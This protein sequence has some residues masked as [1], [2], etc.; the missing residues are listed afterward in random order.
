MSFLF[1]TK[2]S[3]V[4]TSEQIKKEHVLKS[5]EVYQKGIANVLDVIA[6]S[7]INITPNYIQL[8]G[9]Y[10]RTLFVHTYSK[11]LQTNWLSPVIN[12]DLT[13][14]IGMFIYPV[15]SR[16]ILK[17]LRKK[18]AQIQSSIIM[19]QEKGEVRDPML[20]AA[21]VNAEE[22]RDKLMQG[23]E[24]FFKYALYFTLYAEC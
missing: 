24:R 19:A 11:Y 3:K 6:P 4:K 7:A 8:G 5:E 12:L 21:F 22:L 10:I 15:D 9:M 18:V 13:V 23:T 20:E 17:N 14:D 1:K 16:I 2:K